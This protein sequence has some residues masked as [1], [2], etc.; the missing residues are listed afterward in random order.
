MLYKIKFV[1]MGNKFAFNIL[2]DSTRV[3]LLNDRIAS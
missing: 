3:V 1:G 2:M